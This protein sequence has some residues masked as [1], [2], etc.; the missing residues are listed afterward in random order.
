MHI[1]RPIYIWEKIEPL[2]QQ[3]HGSR[4][5]FVDIRSNRSLCY[6]LIPTVHIVIYLVA[7][8]QSNSLR[9]SVPESHAADE[10]IRAGI[11]S[12]AFTSAR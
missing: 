12:A 9:S 5:M 7:P 11:T 2:M 8:L 3:S 6:V 4:V 10:A 1:W